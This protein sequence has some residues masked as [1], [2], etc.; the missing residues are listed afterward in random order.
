MRRTRIGFL[1]AA[2]ACLFLTAGAL[3]Q[4][5]PTLS[6]ATGLIESPNAETV[7]VGRFSF[8]LSGSLSPLMAGPSLTVPPL[9]D[10]PLRYNL[11]RFGMT[12]GYGLTPTLEAF[13][14]FGALQYKAGYRDWAGNINGRDRTGGFNTTETDKFRVGMKWVMNPRDPVKIAT[15]L[16]VSF[17]T[18]GGTGDPDSFSTGRTDYDFGLSFN[19]DWFTL[20][21]T[22]FVNS[23]YGTPDAY[24]G[25]PTVGAAVPNQWTWRAGAILP[26]VPDLVNGVFEIN[27][28]FFY[29]GEANPKAYSE[30]LLGG[31]VGLGKGT[32]LVA[33]GA[34]RINVDEWKYGSDPLPLGGVLQISWSPQ[35]TAAA[36]PVVAAAPREIPPTE[37]VPPPPP[38]PPAPAP[39]AAAPA[40]APVPRPVTTTTDELLYDAGKSRLTNI[41]K[42]IL[43]GVALRLK[44]NLSATCTISGWADP[45]EK[46]DRM[47]LAKA[48]AEAAKDYL[49][50]RHGIDAGRMTVEARGDGDAS[51]AT[52]N[53]RA[54]VTVTF[55]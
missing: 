16:G 22:Y 46:G 40:A 38:P 28:N 29:G 10:D 48:R 54:V 14:N 15:V 9:P 5:A 3:A 27:R 12:V 50:K 51:D 1:L 11:G 32:G 6:G 42:A 34:L 20:S 8:A 26:L 43:D 39:A 53:R 13:L 18:G 49:V 19:Y 44:N 23:N 30:A 52:R 21:T 36:R 33:T 2:A 25:T 45:K 17:P 37:P 35:P 55:P 24:Y 41:A 7:P 31:R 47:A 4:P